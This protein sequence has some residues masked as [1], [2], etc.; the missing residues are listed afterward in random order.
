L[1]GTRSIQNG[2]NGVKLVIGETD[3]G[4]SNQRVTLPLRGP[5]GS[6]IAVDLGLPSETGICYQRQRFSCGQ[7]GQ[8]S[9]GGL[10]KRLWIT[11]GLGVLCL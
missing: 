11:S 5:S 7:V 9:A 4:F 3:F 2:W 6:S 10:Q 8:T 1:N